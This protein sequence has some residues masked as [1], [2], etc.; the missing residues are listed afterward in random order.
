[1][2]LANLLSPNPSLTNSAPVKSSMNLNA[3][4]LNL[5]GFLQVTAAAGAGQVIGNT[6][7]VEPN[8]SPF[9]LSAIELVSGTIIY[10]SVGG[11]LTINLPPVASLNLYLLSIGASIVNFMSFS[12]RVINPTGGSVSVSNNS[13]TDWSLLSEQATTPSTFPYV[14]L[15]NT[16][17]RYDVVI[18]NPLTPAATLVC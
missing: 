4:D 13:D 10:N 8:S 11:A 5:T 1:M 2:S 9:A 6:D 17:Q 18:T 16:T 14:Q 12:F 3:N 15:A 7:I